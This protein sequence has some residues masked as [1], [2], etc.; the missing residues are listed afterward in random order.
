MK[1]CPNILNFGVP[2]NCINAM[3]RVYVSKETI[4]CMRGLN[5]VIM[6]Q[7]LRDWTEI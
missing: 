1:Y 7:A 6:K 5:E 2:L 3:H 4:L